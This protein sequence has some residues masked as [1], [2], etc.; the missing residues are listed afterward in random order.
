MFL[1]VSDE[2]THVQFK[3]ASA[4]E[5]KLAAMA[6][7]GWTAEECMVGR[8]REQERIQRRP[9]PSMPVILESAGALLEGPIHRG[10]ELETSNCN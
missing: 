9:E 6:A 3:G 10:N 7:F 1:S 8:Q 2:S 5:K 4:S